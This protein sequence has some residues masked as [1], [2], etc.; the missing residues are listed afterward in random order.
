MKISASPYAELSICSDSIFYVPHGVGVHAIFNGRVQC[1]AD[2]SK[3][4]ISAEIM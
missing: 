2:H 4:R 3:S 1:F